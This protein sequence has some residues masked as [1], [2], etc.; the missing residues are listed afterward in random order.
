M[1]NSTAAN[2]DDYLPV[3]WARGRQKTGSLY[4]GMVAFGYF[5]YL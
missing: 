5:A 1:P 4:S 2:D 3:C